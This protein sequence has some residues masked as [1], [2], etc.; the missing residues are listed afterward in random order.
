MDWGWF[1]K[2]CDWKE[3]ASLDLN[4]HS[5]QQRKLKASMLSTCHGFIFWKVKR[6]KSYECFFR[7]WFSSDFNCEKNIGQCWHLWTSDGMSPCTEALCLFNSKELA[8]EWFGDADNVTE[9]EIK[10]NTRRQ[11]QKRKREE[12]ENINPTSDNLF[13]DLSCICWFVVAM[14]SLPLF[15]RFFSYYIF[16]SVQKT[17][18]C[19]FRIN[20]FVLLRGVWGAAAPKQKST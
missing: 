1:C 14:F 18:T 12:K 20:K 9:H 7:V 15:S 11:K 2:A 5:G 10:I 8:M 17:H 19:P 3:V 6:I 16:Q 4:T 13:D